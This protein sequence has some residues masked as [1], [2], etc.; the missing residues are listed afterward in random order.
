MV[1]RLLEK[2]KELGIENDTIVVYS[3]DDGAEAFTWPDDGTTM[4]RGEKD[5]SWEGRDRVPAVIRW[6][7]VV[8]PGTIVDDIASHEDW[9]P[10]LLAAAGD[11]TRRK[12][13]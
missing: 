3:T 1:G 13:S 6:P 5:T 11:T 9:L 12:T 4:F 10:T 2:L 8:K 7:G